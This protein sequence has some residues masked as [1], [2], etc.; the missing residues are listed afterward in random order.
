[1]SE[2]PF[3]H[4]RMFGY[5]LVLL[6]PPWRYLNWS[7]KGEA[8]NPSAHY[9]CMTLDQLKALPVGHLAAPDSAC[10]MW[11]IAPM[12][13]QAI[14]LMEAYG[15]TFK[16]AGAWGKQSSTGRKWQFGP[17]YILRSAAEFFIIGTIGSPPVLSHSE[18]NLIVAPVREH[19]RKPD[20]MHRK[21]EALYP[22][23]RCELFART[24]REGWD[25][26]GNETEKFTA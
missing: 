2:W 22:G 14:D 7:A 16:T 4:L 10:C 12:L 17:G 5:G 3:G 18:R 11:A 21:L 6:D 1:M 9:D 19:S 20:D 13:D 15:F 26:W 24:K 8:K 23:P 25:C